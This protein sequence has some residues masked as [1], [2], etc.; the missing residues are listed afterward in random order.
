MAIPFAWYFM[1]SWLENYEYRI[2]VAWWIFGLTG[3]GVLL[4]TL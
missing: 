4:L 2:K 1:N 3:I